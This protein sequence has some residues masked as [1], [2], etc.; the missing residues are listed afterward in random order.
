MA[1]I[2]ELEELQLAL[3]KSRAAALSRAEAAQA[4]V[5][6]QA[7]DLRLVTGHQEAGKGEDA[8]VVKRLEAELHFAKARLEEVKAEWEAAAAEIKRLKGAVNNL[9]V[10]VSF[11]CRS[12]TPGDAFWYLFFR[13]APLV[14][15]RLESPHP[16][17]RHASAALPAISLP[18]IPCR[19]LILR[20]PPLC[21]CH[22]RKI[23]FPDSSLTIP[24]PH[25]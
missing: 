9:E 11:L 3:E 19:H 14:P 25:S 16:R 10:Q 17:L 1:K 5:E 13:P 8:A 20:R 24:R 22:A 4:A 7:A 21:L 18:L 15:S 2:Q 6:A 23:V 12:F